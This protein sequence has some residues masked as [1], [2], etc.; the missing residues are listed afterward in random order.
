[1]FGFFGRLQKKCVNA[2]SVGVDFANRC[3]ALL[4]YNNS[5]Q[6]RFLAEIVECGDWFEIFVGF[7][8]PFGQVSEMPAFFD[9]SFE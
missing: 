9:E 8:V 6:Q 3:A 2:A 4:E 7:G 1:V 5:I